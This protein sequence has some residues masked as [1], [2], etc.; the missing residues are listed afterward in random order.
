MP[1][2]LAIALVTL[3]AAALA[4]G[5]SAAPPSYSLTGHIKVD[6]GGW[7]YASFDAAHGR[8][9]VSR[10]AGAVTV[11]DVA[12][13]AVSTL[14]IPGSGRM[15]ESLPLNH[16]ALLLV[17]D[18]TAN[19]AHLIEPATG[20]SVADVPTGTKPDAAA[21]DPASGLAL[22]MNGKSGDVT[23]IDPATHA[24]VA[25]AAVGG[26]LEFAAVDG[27]GK[28][29]VNIEDQNQM[30]V[31]DTK[32]HTLIGHYALAGC[33]SPSGLAYAPIGTTK[34]AGVLIAACANKVAKVLSAADG[35][36]VA[37]LTIGAGPDAVIY[38][39]VRKLAFI[40]CGRD[41]VLEVIAVRGPSDVAVVATVTTQV[42]AR[43]GA[44]D[45]ATGAL[46]L[47]TAQFQPPATP[48]GGRPAAIPGTFEILVVTPA[49]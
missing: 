23:F 13:K 3:A 16:G 43:T 35:H 11:V 31:I 24:A 36:D 46:Y 9:F 30:G 4:A 21:F 34:A 39:P 7:D 6:D 45:P 25:T 17:T 15:H 32:T 41:G 28:A 26:A 19:V 14:T 12:T 40:P 38:D 44:V 47:P 5:A 18:G 8:V 27:A 37:T 33:D 29:F 42:G 22:V 10:S 49:R 48:G 2:S 20:A 1:Q